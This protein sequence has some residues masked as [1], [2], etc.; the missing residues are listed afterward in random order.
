MRRV[1]SRYSLF[2]LSGGSSLT[3]LPVTSEERQSPERTSHLAGVFQQ[4][5]R[6]VASHAGPHDP[7]GPDRS[8][9]GEEIEYHTVTG[10]IPIAAAPPV[11]FRLSS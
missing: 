3:K 6:A 10:C 5:K 7:H 2:R 1:A 8:P 4:D 9:K 11:P